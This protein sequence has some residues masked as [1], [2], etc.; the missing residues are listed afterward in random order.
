MPV[1]GGATCPLNLHTCRV[2][3][4]MWV[5]QVLMARTSFTKGRSLVQ[6]HMARGGSHPGPSSSL[7]RWLTL[8]CQA[9]AERPPRGSGL[10]PSP[11]SG[12]GCGEGHL[13]RPTNQQTLSGV[14]RSQEGPGGLA[15][16]LGCSQDRA[17]PS[18]RTGAARPAAKPSGPCC[19]PATTGRDVA[20][21]GWVAEVREGPGLQTFPFPLAIPT[22]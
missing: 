9:C 20:A 1:A 21:P 11:G 8:T 3:R 22:P 13:P 10:W 4:V 19:L 18:R 12:R 2:T 15:I 6:G 7:L 16:S 14:E 5:T 17:S